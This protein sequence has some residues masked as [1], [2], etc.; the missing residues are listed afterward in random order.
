MRNITL[1]IDEDVLSEVR[2]YAA[3][4]DTTVNALVRAHLAQLARHRS[5]ARQAMRELREMSDTSDVAIGEI[6]WTRDDLHDR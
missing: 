1:A 5:R 2:R 3:E 4:H 6:G